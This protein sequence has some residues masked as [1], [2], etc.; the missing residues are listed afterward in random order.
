MIKIEKAT[1]INAQQIADFQVLMAKETEDYA[2]DPKIVIT[3]VTHVFDNPIIGHYYIFKYED[4]VVGSALTLYEW[5]D[6]RNGNIVWIHS[7]FVQSDY[8]KLGLF[9]SFYEAMKKRVEEDSQLKGLRLYVDKT[10]SKA[11]Q[12]YQNLGMQDQHYSLF[13]WLES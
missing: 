4:I 8:R 5:S 2:L 1:K 11:I 6:W 3:G 13:E 9:R 12:V 10:N 7:V